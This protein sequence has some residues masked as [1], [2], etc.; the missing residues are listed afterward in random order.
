VNREAIEREQCR[1]WLRRNSKVLLAALAAFL[2]HLG[3]AY[4]SPVH[5][6]EIK[7]ALS[8]LFND[9][10]DLLLVEMPLKG[11]PNSPLMLF[12]TLCRQLI[13][14]SPFDSGLG[15]PNLLIM[16]KS[17]GGKTF[18]A[19]LKLLMM[20]RARPLVS[21]LERGDSYGPL[22]ELMGGRVINVDLDG[23]ETLNP[24]DLPEGETLP[25]NEKTAFLKNLTQHMLGSNQGSDTALLDNVLTDAITRVYRRCSIR[26]SNPIPTF[27]D[28][29]EEPDRGE[30]LDYSDHS[31]YPHT[32]VLL[33]VYH[34]PA[35]VEIQGVLSGQE[36]GSTVAGNLAG[37]GQAVPTR[38][39]RC[40]TLFRKR[41]PA[42]VKAATVGKP[43]IGTGDA[44]RR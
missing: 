34:L 7:R 17:G 38:I 23:R 25:S 15:G 33:G 37:L 10:A 13:P 32:T 42:P 6:T 4:P 43:E 22:I 12:E 36:C 11:T 14:F 3:S 29:R 1:A 39:V 27:N 35:Q 16:A 8:A 20:A 2:L 21:I 9:V 19:Q 40:W 30:G 44:S 18:L 28:L 24:W 26:Y 41:S 31:D 5:L